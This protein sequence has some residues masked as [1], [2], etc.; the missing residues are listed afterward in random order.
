[1]VLIDLLLAADMEYDMLLATQNDDP[2]GLPVQPQFHNFLYAKLPIS[3]AWM[4]PRLFAR[5]DDS[6][7]GIIENKVVDGGPKAFP[8]LRQL[9][10][11]FRGH[12]FYKCVGEIEIEVVGGPEMW[13]LTEDEIKQDIMSEKVTFDGGD[14]LLRLNEDDFI[15]EK[16][17]LHCGSKEHNPVSQMRFYSKQDVP[18]LKN[19]PDELP[20]AVE[21]DEACLP[22]NTLK[23]FIKR[24]IRLYSRS[25]EKNEFITHVFENWISHKE[26]R[27]GAPPGCLMKIFA[28]EEGDGEEGNGSQP[29]LLTQ[30][31]SFAASPTPKRVKRK[32]GL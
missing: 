13:Q 19:T 1:M 18:K 21:V 17:E 12:D 26:E 7:I 9:L 14:V 5:F 11:R 15:V 6:I 27:M 31:D 28:V 20:V 8:R 24:S 2:D 32:L 30:D 29:V 23:S 22:M 16:R 3:R 25:S 4:Y 10:K